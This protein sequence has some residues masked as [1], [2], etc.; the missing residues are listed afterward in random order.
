VRRAEGSA[1]GS[2]GELA[3]A[4][5]PQRQVGHWTAGL[6]GK[7]HEGPPLLNR[8]DRLL[9]Q[10]AIHSNLAHPVVAPQRCTEARATTHQR[11]GHSHEERPRAPAAASWPARL[12]L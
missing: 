11:T 4:P 2:D 9:G 12:L 8:E 5:Q 3:D 10:G 1:K 7:G 6:Q